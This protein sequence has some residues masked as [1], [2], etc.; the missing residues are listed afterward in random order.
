MTPYGVAKA[1]AHFI[2]GS[3]RR[4]YDLHA[5]SGILYNHESPRRPLDF[6]PRK[7][8][9]AVARIAEG[10]Q[11]ELWVG[12]L[13]AR[14][15]WGWAGD[16]VRAM[17]LMLQRDEA[18]DYVIATGET[19]SVEELVACAFDRVGLDPEGLRPRRRDAASREGAAARPR[20]RPDEGARAARLG[21]DGRLRR[22]RRA[23]RG[24]GSRARAGGGC[25][26]HATA[27][28]CRPADAAPV[29][30][31]REFLVA[32]GAI[33]A[34]LTLAIA[35][36]EGLSPG[37]RAVTDRMTLPWAVLLVGVAAVLV[38]V[39]P[40][41]RYA[42]A[43]G[44]AL[45]AVSPA[46]ALAVVVAVGT[47]VQV[48][49]GAS[50]T[51]PVVLGDELVLLGRGE[52]RRARRPA[53]VPRRVHLGHSVLHPLVLGPFFAAV[54]AV[55][56]LL[57]IKVAQALLMALAAIPA[58]LLARRVSS[59]G[60]SLAVAALTPSRRGRGTRR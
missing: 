38:S 36:A 19:H 4:R 26:G 48:V 9:H 6:L 21:A 43:L 37:F 34:A 10:L 59:H 7:V 44:R 31:H 42:A 54:D 24:R 23:A 2:V 35:C 46:A 45:A 1:Y 11:G 33:V 55:G 16:S 52:E 39:G 3:Y 13:D 25:A 5:S 14:R 28:R 18:D 22:A 27:K 56:A 32:A 58:Y 17:W 60:W 30:S 20:G 29:S 41:R 49:R 51:L 8:S 53:P 15:D 57:A 40:T 12:D 50:S 47:V